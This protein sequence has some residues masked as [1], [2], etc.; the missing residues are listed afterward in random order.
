[1]TFKRILAI[2]AVLA[3]GA[4]PALADVSGSPLVDYGNLDT[5]AGCVFPLIQFSG[6]SAGQ[7]VISYSFYA[8]TAGAASVTGNYLTPVLFEEV[9][10]PEFTIRG[11][12]ATATGFLND[13][14]N[15]EP[16]VATS[17]S[18][19]VLDANTFFGYVDGNAA[20][21]VKNTGT[22]SMN[23]PKYVGPVLYFSEPVALAVGQTVNMSSL[24]SVSQGS[25]TYALQVTTPEPGFYSIF[26][27]LALALTGLFA[28]MGRRK[29]A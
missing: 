22:V 5:C 10:G 29:N 2:C 23:Y 17:G 15:T 19:T 28:A 1:M 12:G 21:T 24:A 27:V 18:A 20:S 9:S 8:G 13:A 3:L 4:I 26:A 14:I 11:I 6:A 7:S 25:R 16:F